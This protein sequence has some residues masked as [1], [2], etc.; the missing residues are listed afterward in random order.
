MSLCVCDCGAFP[1][2]VLPERLERGIPADCWKPRWME[3]QRVQ[4]KGVLSWLVRWACRA[5]T[6]D[7]CS[8]L[9]ALVGPVQNIFSPPY[10][11]SIPLSPY[12]SPGKLGR[13]PCWVACLLGESLLMYVLF[14][15]IWR[16]TYWFW[17]GEIHFEGNRKGGGHENRDFFWPW[18][19]NERGRDKINSLCPLTTPPPPSGTKWIY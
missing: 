8:A 3:T 11:I 9:A 18:N 17:W 1:V 16:R 15:S 14:I 5:G 10:T 13:Q 6:R 19:G 7:F 2:C 12:A 4:M